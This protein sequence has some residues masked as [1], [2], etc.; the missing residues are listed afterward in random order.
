MRTF[1]IFLSILW[2]T[3]FACESTEKTVEPPTE[4]TIGTFNL[5]FLPDQLDTGDIPR[6]AEDMDNLVRLIDESGWQLLT[7][8]EVLSADSLR[9]LQAHGLSSAWRLALGA[10][11]GT[12]K[13]GILYDTRVIDGLDDVH[14]LDNDDGLIPA[15]W[16]GL[17]Y[18]LAAT[19]R[20]L[21]G[22]TFTVVCV[23]LKAGITNAGASQRARQVEQ[24]AAWA[25]GRS[26]PLLIMGDF[27]DTF[28]G[29]HGT[30]VTLT[31]LQEAGAEVGR[32][33]TADLPAGDFTSLE[34]QDLIDHV[35]ISPDLDARVV[36]GSL[37]TVK[38]DQDVS[39]DGL[40]ISDHRP[41]RFTIHLE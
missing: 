35:F 13:V 23:H 30:I 8:Q 33:L 11:G 41:V 4:L 19:V 34:F 17:R 25:A 9:L 31:A 21:G 28:E 37:A 22:F 32:F 36:P 18:P 3:L 26:T 5:Q 24:L 14:E 12:Q 15:D 10:S 29:I 16:S 20:V 39:Y 6:S 38:F 27:N 2:L 7:V 1:I 40:T